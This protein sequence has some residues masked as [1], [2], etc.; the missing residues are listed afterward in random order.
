MTTGTDHQ[1]IIERQIDVLY[2]CYQGFLKRGQRYALVDFPNHSNVGDSAIW[3]GELRVLHKI[4]GHEP[5][6][7]CDLKNYDRDDL[8]AS[9][10]AGPI[11]IHGGGNFGDIWQRHHDLRLRL[12]ADFPDRP[13]VQL[14][15][16]ICFNDPKWIETTARAI[17]AHGGFHLIVRDASSKA[18]A[19][20]QLG[21]EPILAPDS[22]FALGAQRRRGAIDRDVV[23]LLRT[24][25]E[26]VERSIDSLH[27]MPGVLIDDWIVEGRSNM[28]SY[29]RSRI[30][31]A[32][33]WRFSS[34]ERRL[35][36]YNR[37]ANWRI[38]RGLHLLSRGNV[39]IT[40]RLHA[41][42]LSSLL[43]IPHVA[44]DNSYGKIGS[45]INAW[46]HIYAD[47]RTAT[48]MA[49]AVKEAK[50]L[51]DSRSTRPVIVT[52]AA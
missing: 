10:P 31:S 40:D 12:M 22:A 21:I 20:D 46:T 17:R 27:D 52:A 43:G 23:A 19:M 9:L 33:R 5:S 7:V 32:L 28:A 25:S 2:H 45:Y 8:R 48:N 41:H 1:S 42:I 39:V 51:L 15:Q 35:D 26:G 29:K 47:V 49:D 11:L 50:Q 38:E 37:L 44:L 4:A 13:I 18:I 34:Q 36:Y 3:A 24:D 6:Y 16:S 30:Q 14:P